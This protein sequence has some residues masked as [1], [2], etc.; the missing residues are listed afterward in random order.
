MKGMNILIFLTAHLLNWCENASCCSSDNTLLDFTL[1]LKDSLGRERLLLRD[2][3]QG[4]QL[5]FQI[6]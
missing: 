1:C 5:S 2:D 3:G 6:L 4:L